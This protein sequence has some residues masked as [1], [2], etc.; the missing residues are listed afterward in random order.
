[1]LTKSQFRMAL[2]ENERIDDLT[3]PDAGQG[4]PDPCVSAIRI[5]PKILNS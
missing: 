3:R 5:I 1:M 4:E 2:N